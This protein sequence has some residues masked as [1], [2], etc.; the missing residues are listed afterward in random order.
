MKINVLRECI[1]MIAMVSMLSGCLKSPDITP[2]D[3]KAYLSI[4]H[5]VPTA[6]SIDVF[7]NDQKVSNNPFA[8]GNVTVAYNAIDKGTFSIKF[9]KVASDSLV[10]EVPM[11][12]Y[13]SL[14]FYT[15]FIY[16]QQANGP[17]KAVRVKD[18][19]SNILADKPYYR[20]FHASP[21]TGAVDLYIDNVKM[22][23][24]R[25]LADNTT[26]DALNK[27]LAATTGNHTVQVRLAGTQTVVASL[28][29]V[30]LQAMN[31]YT[32]YLRGL[33]GGTGTSELSLGLLRAVN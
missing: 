27:F 28:N 3:P 1:A 15:L 13:D 29:N 4:M 23:S 30:G 19:F 5:L 32:F 26:N 11:A 33:D 6:P 21:N 14:S 31:A 24:G 12:K 20:F 9:K 10:A 7:F 16:N 8:P 25:L 22:E 17:A 18:D 2:P